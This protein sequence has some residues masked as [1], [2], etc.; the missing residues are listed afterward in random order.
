MPRSVPEM[1]G[2]TSLNLLADALGEKRPVRFQA[3]DGLTIHGYLTLPPG[4]PARGLPMVLLVH[5]GP[6]ARDGWSV[7]GNSRGLQQFLA[8][9]KAAG[10]TEPTAHDRTRR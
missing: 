8:N 10:R 9:R 5:G 4:V 7:S 3:R 1:L 6:W 2:Q